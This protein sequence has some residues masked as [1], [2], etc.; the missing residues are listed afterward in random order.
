[1]LKWVCVDELG[2]YGYREADVPIG[3]R[4]VLSVDTDYQLL[5]EDKSL[6][7]PVQHESVYRPLWKVS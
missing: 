4:V 1:M 3:N 7:Q 5:D 2:V 6:K